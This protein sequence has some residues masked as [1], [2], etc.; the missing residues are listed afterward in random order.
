M[1]SLWPTWTIHAEYLVTM[2]K[3]TSWLGFVINIHRGWFVQLTILLLPCF[4]SS[5]S[6]IILLKQSFF[7]HCI[8]SPIME[9]EFLTCYF[10]LMHQAISDCDFVILTYL[11][12]VGFSAMLHWI[13]T[14]FLYLHTVNVIHFLMKKDKKKAKPV[15]LIIFFI[16]IFFLLF[17]WNKILLL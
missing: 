7:M 16:F 6:N 15:T 12:K 11:L 5:L 3:L 17:I 14:F 13:N 8:F 9:V 10:L 4:F 2:F 1:S